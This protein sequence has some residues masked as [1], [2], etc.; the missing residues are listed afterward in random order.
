M[1]SK[2]LL[3]GRL[4]ADPEV[5]YTPDGTAVV[6]LRIAT[7]EVYKD[8]SGDNQK[9]TEW[10]S[11]VFFGRNAENAANYLAKGRLVMVEGQ[12]RTRKWEDKNGVNHYTTEVVGRIF[13][14]LDSGKGNGGGQQR[15]D[16]G[17]YP[18]AAGFPATPVPEDD[19]PF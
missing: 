13:K 9:K 19:V 15:D 4:G 16:Y 11:V 3:I 2:T 10:H 6:N 8:K 17:G 14:M 18:E 12:N 1:F 5:R 7:D